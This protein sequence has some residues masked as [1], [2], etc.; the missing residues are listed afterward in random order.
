MLRLV[1]LADREVSFSCVQCEHTVACWALFFDF[2]SA[3][4]HLLLVL[5]LLALFKPTFSDGW[6]GRCESC[7][8]SV[9]TFVSKV[10]IRLWF[11]HFRF[12][13]VSVRQKS[14]TGLDIN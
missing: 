6:F 2:I 7:E 1:A 8:H 14:A 3:L 12:H 4:L 11:K 5:L 13:V 9:L 10:P